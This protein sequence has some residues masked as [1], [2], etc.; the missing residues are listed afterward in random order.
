MTEMNE[1]DLE[2]FIKEEHV[3][4]T[5]YKDNL[6][7]LAYVERLLRIMNIL[8]ERKLIDYK[9]LDIIW[10]HQLGK[11]DAIQR[12]V[13]AILSK[14]AVNF[15]DEFFT[16]LF[17]KIEKSWNEGDDKVKEVVLDLMR[18]LGIE[19]SING[20]RD[21][22]AIV[23]KIIAICWRWSTA[24]EFGCWREK[25]FTVIFDVLHDTVSPRKD[26]TIL[27]EQ[28]IT[29]AE[30]CLDPMN[31]AAED[32][33]VARCL[34]FLRKLICLMPEEKALEDKNRNLLI[35]RLDEKFSPDDSEESTVFAFGIQVAQHICVWITQV[36]AKVGPIC[37]PD[38]ILIQFRDSP[39][40]SMEVESTPSSEGADQEDAYFANL[41]KRLDFFHFIIAEARRCYKEDFPIFQSSWVCPPPFSASQL[42][43][44]LSPC[45][46]R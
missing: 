11:H 41:R 43:F 5:L 42:I 16:N 10:D 29:V 35:R 9:V 18:R 26:F 2:E 30:S 20:M 45:G 6:H 39:V 12:N 44:R 28:I 38:N 23:R 15:L 21:R 32:D 37:Y 7:H 13:N 8:L 1:E 4:E 3:V 22:V 40:N 36:A 33:P 17:L 46:T 34:H 14:I 24:S 27:E 25:L 19:L 31:C